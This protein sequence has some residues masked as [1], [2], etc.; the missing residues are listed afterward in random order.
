VVSLALA[1]LAGLPAGFDLTL[2]Y[3]GAMLYLAVV[4]SILGF[5]AYLTLISRIGADRAAYTSVL[6][7]TVAL[8]VS[9]AFEGYR[10]TIEGGV[11]VVLILLGNLV[12]LARTAPPA[13]QVARAARSASQ[14]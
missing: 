9:T 13:A 2:S 3:L 1:A 10:W 4:S 14:A 12:A 11:G 7:P 8:A 6:F 5:G